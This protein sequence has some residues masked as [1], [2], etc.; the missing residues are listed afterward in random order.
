[1]TKQTNTS[2]THQLKNPWTL[3]SL[4]CLLGLSLTYSEISLKVQAQTPVTKLAAIHA[5]QGM[6]SN[7][8]ATLDTTHGSERELAFLNRA[9]H[10][11]SSASQDRA[12]GYSNERPNDRP[13]DR[14]NEQISSAFERALNAA[15]AGDIE[16]AVSLYQDIVEAKPNHQMAGINMA[17]LQQRQGLWGPSQDTLAK[18]LKVAGGSRKGKIY[19]LQGRAYEALGEMSD[20]A[21]R[22]RQSIDYRPAHIATWRRLADVSATLKGN[23]TLSYRESTELFGKVIALDAKNSKSYLNK[24]FHQFAR[25]DFDG[26]LETLEQSKIALFSEEHTQLR[27]QLMLSAYLERGKTAK[28]KKLLVMKNKS[29]ASVDQD[30]LTVFSKISNRHYK[31][32]LTFW[33]EKSDI[34]AHQ[35]NTDTHPRYSEEQILDQILLAYLYRKNRLFEQ[36]NV[37]LTELS[38][39]AHAANLANYYTAKVSVALNSKQS[40][41]AA[42]GLLLSLLASSNYPADVARHLSAISIKL[43]SGTDALNYAEIALLHGGKKRRYELQQV[44]AERQFGDLNKAISMARS[45]AEKYPKSR[46]MLR[47][48]ADSLIDAGQTDLA[49]EKYQQLTENNQRKRDLHTLA[50]LLK[51]KNKLDESSK[52]LE[53]LLAKYSHDIDARFLLAENYCLKQNIAA[54]M[55][56]ASRVLRLDN[57]HVGAQALIDKLSYT[58]NHG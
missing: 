54:C 33:Q 10:D 55:T 53:D 3:I 32:A 29:K 28:I 7:D 5:D 2:R 50:R 40:L 24:A 45:L 37:V 43:T 26:A 36:A 22:Y 18:V 8:L 21:K 49:I 11:A 51:A 9:E 35:S 30:L 17:I 15:K 48:W 56:Q 31:K 38:Q 14:S 27:D 52:V 57:K 12:N 23:D 41:S 1:M 16:R 46:V 39:Q 34:R 13:H 47:L 58:K 44:E 4:A 19:A 25:L 6:Y 42:K 20:A